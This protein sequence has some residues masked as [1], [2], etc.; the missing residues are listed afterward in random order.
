MKNF[1]LF[2]LFTTAAMLMLAGCKDKFNAIEGKVYYYEDTVYQF[3]A[4]FD[5]DTMYYIMKDQGPPRFHKSPFTAKKVNDSVF[6]IQVTSKPKFWEKDTWEI[7]VRND[8]E[9]LSTES[10][11]KYDRYKIGMQ[12]L[13]DAF[14]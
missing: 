4:G 5:N 7:T 10:G 9:F 3:T 13:K 8:N 12:E 2:F 6:T 11:K 14:K 1:I